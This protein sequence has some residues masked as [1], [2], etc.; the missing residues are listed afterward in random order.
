MN[1]YGP[2]LPATGGGIFGVALVWGLSTNMLFVAIFAAIGLLITAYSFF[3][4]LKGE[5]LI[6]RI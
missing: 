1:G 6:R 4:L 2:T 5:S 3:R